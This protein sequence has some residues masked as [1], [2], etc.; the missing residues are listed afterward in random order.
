MFCLGRSI[1]IPSWF[2]QTPAGVK[3]PLPL[4]GLL[5]IPVTGSAA[6]LHHRVQGG[7]PFLKGSL[8][9]YKSRA[10]EQKFSVCSLQGERLLNQE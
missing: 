3:L 1:D 4:L 5:N 6:L 8:Q 10:G 9:I 2:V 7:S